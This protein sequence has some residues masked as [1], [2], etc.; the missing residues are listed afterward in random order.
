M[1][2]PTLIQ[3]QAIGN[4][5]QHITDGHPEKWGNWFF[6]TLEDW[7]LLPKSNL[8]ASEYYTTLANLPAFPKR[9]LCQLIIMGW[10]EH[11]D[12]L[13]LYESIITLI[14]LKVCGPCE[15][16]F[17]QQVY[18]FIE[19]FKDV[20]DEDRKIFI[21]QHNIN[22]YSIR[23]TE[24]G[25]IMGETLALVELEMSPTTDAPTVVIAPWY[26]SFDNLKGL[27]E[28]FSQN[29]SDIEFVNKE[30]VPIISNE[31]AKRHCR[32][33]HS[34][35]ELSF[36]THSQIDAPVIFIKVREFIN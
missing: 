6:E 2:R 33:I 9:I 24:D 3:R 17:I 19:H 25:H 34:V 14:Q 20:C 26:F 35:C 12:Y 31:F 11:H 10:N 7:D 22:K 23:F 32:W 18:N 8:S 36:R 5:L 29:E 30:V 28:G 27:P 4:M 21:Q 16:I 15:Y 1:N 13:A